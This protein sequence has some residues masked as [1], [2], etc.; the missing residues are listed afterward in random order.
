MKV[1]P[2]PSDTIGRAVGE[3]LARIA[4]NSWGQVSSSVYE[5]AR[6]VATAHWLDGH[7]GRVRFLLDRQRADG[8]WGPPEGYALVPTLSAVDALLTE[9]ARDTG[10]YPGAVADAACRGLAW[11]AATLR[12]DRPAQIPDTIADEY[13]VPWLTG[14]VN[15][16]L[17]HL[18]DHPLPG[19]G[20]WRGAAPLAPPP[21][22]D[23]HRLDRLRA[24]V[25]G[26]G[27]VPEKLWHSLEVLGRAAAGAR[28]VRPA[29]GAVAG[30]PAATVAWLGADGAFAVPVADVL[31]STRYL[32]AMQRPH[33]GPV[34]GVSPITYF[35][36]AW[37]IASL[38]AGG[39]APAVP[40]TVLDSLLASL[41]PQ[42]APAGPG[43]CPDSDDTAAVLHA[44]AC[45]VGHH[46]PDHLWQY[47]TDT[48]FRCF[49]GEQNPSTSANAHVL[50]VLATT[51]A[52]VPERVRTAATK[53]AAWLRDQQAPDGS[54]LDKW[55]ASAHYA[56]ACCALALHRATRCGALDAGEAVRRAVRWTLETQRPDGSWG[57]WEGT[58]EETAYAMQTLLAT[59]ATTAAT[60]GPA[61][62]EVI[63]AAARGY[64][65][66]SREGRSDDDLPALWHDKDLYAP[67][68][69]VRAARLGALHLAATHPEV[70]A[71][72][73]R[74]PAP[75]TLGATHP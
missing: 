44:L 46:P 40:Q 37:V 31:A 10:P 71:A 42:G 27:A 61:G 26:G 74:L 2:A 33:G 17:A 23:G 21:G 51:V 5:T 57:R 13:I 56:T 53:T 45:V 48:Y 30:S 15:R 9:V 20:A 60:T 18:D 73:A 52:D 70:P 47:E 8:A 24:A 69:V 68:E 28:G 32:E 19:L 72:A 58:D 38:A 64:L 50:D 25:R 6:L 4:R 35:E 16:H 43:I 65:F 75:T 1:D 63:R 14:R 11:L 22:L 29:H 3:L 36:R 41:G 39:I 7:A 55:H 12:S 67:L 59:E 49:A 62:A 54:W 34:P 66:L